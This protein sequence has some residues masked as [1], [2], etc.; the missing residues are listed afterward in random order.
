LSLRFIIFLGRSSDNCTGKVTGGERRAARRA[1]DKRIRTALNEKL[2]MEV[3]M[4][5]PQ[6]VT[7]I[8]ADRERVAEAVVK[9]ICNLKQ[10]PLMEAETDEQQLDG[11]IKFLVTSLGKEW[12][13]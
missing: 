4:S 13:K 10:G 1:L 8:R 11:A 12:S 5:I 9:L 7:D 3:E 6:D 2:L